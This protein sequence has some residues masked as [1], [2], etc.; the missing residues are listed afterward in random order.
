[1]RTHAIRFVARKSPARWQ[2][3]ID[4][5]ERMMKALE[6]RNGPLLA[7]ILRE[8]LRHKVGMVNEALAALA[9]HPAK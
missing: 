6:A 4:D 3:A 1:M 7:E 8:H 9:G 5:H 2:E